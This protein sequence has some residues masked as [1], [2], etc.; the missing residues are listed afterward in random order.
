[1]AKLPSFQFYPGDWLKDANLRRC[2]HAAKGVWI[3]ILCLMF[4]AD[5]RG[6]LSTNGVAWSDEDIACA[7]GGDTATTVGAIQ[8]LTFKGVAKRRANGALYS[9][10]MV[11]DENKRKLC[12]AAGKKGGGNPNL[13]QKGET[14]KGQPKGEVKGSPKQN[15]NPSSSSS[16][17]VNNN[18]Q[19]N[20][21]FSLAE[22]LEIASLPD[23][24]LS[25]AEARKFFDFYAAQDWVRSNG[26][27]ITSLAPAMR[28]WKRNKGKF[29]AVSGG[30]PQGDMEITLDELKAAYKHKIN[31]YD[32][33]HCSTES[34]IKA[35]KSQ[36]LESFK[37]YVGFEY[38]A[39]VEVARK[40]KQ[41]G[42]F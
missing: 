33:M 11:A 10:R 6:V 39:I 41:K 23:V 32:P 13:T 29:D 7:I 25:E 12:S 9:K 31:F 42:K 34:Q 26:Q 15:P 24:A 40:Q 3:D 4:E 17:S 35:L 19:N 2:T 5:E 30:K 16:T 27:R 22:V 8:E 37:R 36:D 28:S 21:G 14:F 20:I 38:E 1:M 18:T